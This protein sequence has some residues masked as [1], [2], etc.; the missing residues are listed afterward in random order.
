MN[1]PTNDNDTEFVMKFIASSLLSD[2]KPACK[3]FSIFFFQI[4]QRL[5]SSRGRKHGTFSHRL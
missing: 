1:N 4:L 2:I 5:L 3:S